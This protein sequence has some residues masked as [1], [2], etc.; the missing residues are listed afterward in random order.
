MLM[1]LCLVFLFY[2]LLCCVP[3]DPFSGLVFVVLFS[4]L[5]IGVYFLSVRLA[6]LLFSVLWFVLFMYCLLFALLLCPSFLVSHVYVVSLVF[7][8]RYNCCVRSLLSFV[9]LIVFLLLA[10]F[11]GSSLSPPCHLSCCCLFLPCPIWSHLCCLCSAL[12]RCV[13]LGSDLLCSCVLVACV[14]V[15]ACLYGLLWC[16]SILGCCFCAAFRFM[17]VCSPCHV[18]QLSSPILLSGHMFIAYLVSAILIASI[19]GCCLMCAC[20]IWVWPCLLW[21][22]IL[23]VVLVWSS[24][25]CPCLSFSVFRSCSSLFLCYHFC[26]VVVR[27]L[28]SALILSA[29]VHLVC[30]S[31]LFRLLC[32]LCCCIG[33]VS[34]VVLRCLFGMLHALFLSL[35]VPRSFLCFWLCC[36]LVCHSGVISLFVL[37]SLFS[38]LLNMFSYMVCATLLFSC[39]VC[40]RPWCLSSF[41]VYVSVVYLPSCYVYVCVLCIM[42]SL[43]FRFLCMSV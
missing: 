31:M 13:L 1:F 20:M 35:L 42:F 40:L 11:L 43:S 30:S 23:C 24:R 5:L 15:V 17:F 7:S 3:I 36:L 32:V 12:R 38:F 39:V 22:I 9:Q 8:F 34:V 14:L 10:S 27:C 6:S 26:C 16:L 4:G 33:L 2:V 21:C 37:C 29:C 25:L 19:P 18:C 28:F 41:V